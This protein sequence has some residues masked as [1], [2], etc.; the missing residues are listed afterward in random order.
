MHWLNM[1]DQRFVKAFFANNP[2]IEKIW[3]DDFQVHFKHLGHKEQRYRLQWLYGDEGWGEDEKRKAFK[4]Q[5]RK[6][7]AD[8]GY[9]EEN[10]LDLEQRMYKALMKTFQSAA[11]KNSAA[12]DGTVVYPG[13]IPPSQIEQLKEWKVKGT[14]ISS[15]ASNDEYEVAI[16]KQ[17]ETVKR[18]KK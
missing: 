14:S 4:A 2:W 18:G 11:F 10:I 15:D 3:N 13:K 6:V 5:A 7:L 9:T 17:A 12:R 8:E 16:K 1:T